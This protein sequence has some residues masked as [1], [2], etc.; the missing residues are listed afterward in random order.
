MESIDTTIRH[1]AGQP[2]GATFPEPASETIAF[3]ISSARKADTKPDL[4]A[5]PDVYVECAFR[6]SL[7]VNAQ[8]QCS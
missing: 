5:P 6:D 4:N 2:S 1:T 8:A 3:Q 7:D